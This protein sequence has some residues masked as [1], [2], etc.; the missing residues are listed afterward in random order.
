M[1]GFECDVD[2]N[3]KF[4]ST[5]NNSVSDIKTVCKPSAKL[6]SLYEIL[7]NLSL[8]KLLVAQT[9]SHVYD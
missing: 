8:K 3:T 1:I 6:N 4:L 2:F 5:F 7:C 9:L